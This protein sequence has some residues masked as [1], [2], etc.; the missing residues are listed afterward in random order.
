ML[1]LKKAFFIYIS[2]Y[3]YILILLCLY[4]VVREQNIDSG[5]FLFEAEQKAKKER[6]EK[7]QAKGKQNFVSEE[8]KAISSSGY[9]TATDEEVV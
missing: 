1:L 8:M 3:T 9:S 5:F 2:I 4:V 7:R 6:I